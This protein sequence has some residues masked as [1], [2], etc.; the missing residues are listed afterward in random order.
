M[1][2]EIGLPAEWAVTAGRCARCAA[3]PA[4]CYTTPSRRHMLGLKTFFKKN[5]FIY[6]NL[7]PDLAIVVLS[8]KGMKNSYFKT[9][10]MY[11]EK[12]I[13]IDRAVS[14]EFGNKKRI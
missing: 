5:I 13:A 10:R 11:A 1:C 2:V 12:F 4:P 9:Y 8:F 3:A 6:L 14:E 7:L